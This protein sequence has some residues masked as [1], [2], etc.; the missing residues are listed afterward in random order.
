MEQPPVEEYLSFLWSQMQYDWSVFTTPWVLY[1][2]IPAVLYL[3]F[4]YIKWW[5]LLAPITVPL[6]LLRRSSTPDNIDKK[7]VEESVTRLLKG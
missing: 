2:V 4:F 6:T 1:T 5:I 7:D 3:I